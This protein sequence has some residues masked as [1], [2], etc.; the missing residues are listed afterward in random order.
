MGEPIWSRQFAWGIARELGWSPGGAPFTEDAAVRQQ[1]EELVGEITEDFRHLSPPYV[2]WAE[3]LARLLR[4]REAAPASSDWLLGA[5]R[6]VR[7][8]VA[9]L[10]ARFGMAEPM[11]ESDCW[12]EKDEFDLTLSACLCLE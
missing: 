11:D 1:V 2:D 12:T 6:E 8:Y 5:L 7:T 3:D 4:A 10:R 9:F